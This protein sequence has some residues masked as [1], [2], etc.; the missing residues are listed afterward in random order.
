M[1]VSR[2]VLAVLGIM[3]VAA[4]EAGAA[5]SS[6][7]TFLSADDAVNAL[8]DAMKTDNVKD[9]NAIFGPQGKKILYSGDAVQDKAARQRFL[10][11]FDEKHALVQQGDSKA[12]L[13]IGNDD[14]PFP[15]PVIKK[16]GKWFFD[17]KAGE[18]EILN[19]LIGRNELNTIQTCLA[20]VDAQREYAMKDRDSDG[21]HEYA[22]KFV[23]SPGKKDGLYWE[24][25]EGEDQSPLGD[26]FAKAAAEGYVR[27][28]NPIPYHGYYFKILTAQGSGAHGGA[29]DYI[30]KNRMI[31]GFALVAYPAQY[32]TSGIMTFIVNH[33]GVVYQKNLGKNTANIAKTMKTFNPDA[34]WTKTDI[35]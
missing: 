2:I 23:S 4:C 8:I 6:Q 31:G 20:Y 7:K 28:K 10:D 34:S 14:F 9:L 17:T 1:I 22:Q 24:A 33:D 27:G 32:G 5:G 35:K 13:Q 18:Q 21:F 19:R 16:R 11:A 3:L 29:F 30:V 15:I 25:K 26:L 12:V